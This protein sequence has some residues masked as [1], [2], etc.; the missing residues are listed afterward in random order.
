MSLTATRFA[1]EATLE[2]CLAG[3]HRML[4]P[5][6]GPAVTKVQEALFDL[7][8]S[9]Q[10]P[11]GQFSGPTGDAV[12]KYKTDHNIFPNDPVV[13]PKTM[14]ALDAD[15]VDKPPAPFSDRDE[16]V[17][18][19]DRASVPGVGAFDFTRAD[20]LARRIAG[21][22]FTFDA[23]SS[24]L[25]G[26]LQLALMQSLSAFLDPNG[27]PLGD[28][29]PATWGVGPFDLYHYH[30]VLDT[31]GG[32]APANLVNGPALNSQMG[33]LQ[34]Q[35]LAVPGAVRANAIWAKEFRRLLLTTGLLPQFATLA[36][37]ALI[38]ATANQPLLAVWHSFE[39]PPRWRPAAMQPSSPQR[40]WQTQV[41]PLATLP[42]T[43]IFAHATLGNTTHLLFQVS[44]YIS[45]AA[46]I[47]AMPGSS[48]EVAS[49]VGLPFDDV[50]AAQVL[51]P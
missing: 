28:K 48:I 7:G 23:E 18:W 8:F 43:S 46:V 2:A 42:T 17:S 50:V 30:L 47:T 26:P 12:V 51:L 10:R 24:W 31:K 45:K 4:S 36:S 37:D 35:A 9:L 44:F 49:M 22:P 6:T 21:Q 20:E 27:S 3:T 29:D 11:D 1:G 33:F 38:A 41:A 13:G 14:A 15:C 25:P 19:R 32:N 39:H 5:E 40:H 16:W 34:T